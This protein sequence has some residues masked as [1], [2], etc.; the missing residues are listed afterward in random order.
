[1]T[2]TIYSARRIV[3]MDRRRPFAT[4]VAVRDGYV[5]GVGSLPD[6]LARG[7]A[8]VDATF[9]HH[10]LLP[11]F[12]EGHTH[13]D[14]G[15]VWDHCHCG[16]YDRIDPEGR[17]WPG[18]RDLGAVIERLSQHAHGLPPDAVVL[19]WGFDPI[20]LGVS[21]TRQHLDR[22]SRTQPV[23]VIHASGH[24]LYANT[25]ALRRAGLDSP[26]FRHD[27]LPL[28]PDGLPTGELRGV[29][30]AL[31]AAHAL[32]IVDAMQCRSVGAARAFGRLCVRTGVTT[33]T[34]LANTL[35]GPGYAVLRDATGA[36]EY[37]VRIVAALMAAGRAPGEAI[38][39]A[40][41]LLPHSTDRLR[42]G[43]IKLVLDGSIQAYTAR[44]LAPGYVNGAPNGLWYMAPEHVRECLDLALRHGLQVHIHTNGNQATELALDSIDA[45]L[46]GRARNDF[47]CTLQHVQL[48]TPAQFER[49]ARLGIAANLFVN[50]VYYWGDQ[51]ATK[52]VGPE[53]AARM[54]ACGTALR[55][56]VRLAVH[57]DEPG[58][59][60]A[61][62]FTAWCAVN[63]LSSSGQS[64]GP[65][66]CIGT[67][68]ALTAITLGGA[69]TLG[70]EAE[71]G[72]IEVGKRADF[73]VLEDDP[74]LVA[75]IA[76]KDVRV[77]G[78]VLAG[79][80]FEAAQ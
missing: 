23:V 6:L 2:T 72:S 26:G 52:T 58:T 71:V 61:P 34:D 3:T 42:L 56:G 74:L 1:L 37:P 79:R 57:S 60:M 39:R 40:L 78:T 49:M 17:H 7:P 67:H 54:N 24:V 36:P 51:H 33:A 19:G 80:P 4:H 11:G 48:A 29:D 62:L 22:V 8:E 43:S 41:E 63:R 5:V 45:A 18:L 31:P 28:G 21:F 46:G 20:F 44:L 66:E 73:A 55:A 47:R 53:R 76:I 64:M 68:E 70:L 38:A 27:G 35:D 65:E 13:L 32:G 69:Y 30:V 59:P 16:W 77:W 14:A 15:S 50:H 25:E 12:V 9:A 75:P 10:V